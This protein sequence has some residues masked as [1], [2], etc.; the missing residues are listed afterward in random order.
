MVPTGLPKPFDCLVPASSVG[1]F[2]DKALAGTGILQATQHWEVGRPTEGPNC[3]ATDVATRLK[4]LG[5]GQIRPITLSELL[6][7]EMGEDG[8]N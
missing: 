8:A 2:T 3:M 4:K 7:T 5:F 6:R 1:M